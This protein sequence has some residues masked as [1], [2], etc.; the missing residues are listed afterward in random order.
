M[1]EANQRATFIDASGNPIDTALAT[2]SENK[3]G[4]AVAQLRLFVPP[5]FRQGDFFVDEGTD[6][7]ITD[8][9]ELKLRPER[10]LD[11]EGTGGRT[12]KVKFFY[13]DTQKKLHTAQLTYNITVLDVDETPSSMTLSESTIS[14]PEGS[15]PTGRKIAYIT[16]DDDALGQ[17]HATIGEHPIFEVRNGNELWIKEGVVLDFETARQHD[18]EVRPVVTGMGDAPAPVTLTLTVQ[19]VQLSL[20][21]ATIGTTSHPDIVQA[22]S[23]VGSRV[24]QVPVITNIDVP[25]RYEVLQGGEVS[26]NFYVDSQ[27]ALRIKTVLADRSVEDVELLIRAHAGGEVLERTVSFDI[28]SGYFTHLRETM[29]AFQGRKATFS[30]AGKHDADGDTYEIPVSAGGTRRVEDGFFETKFLGQLGAK[31]VNGKLTIELIR[32]DEA[33]FT[34][35]PGFIGT[36][37][38]SFTILDSRGDSAR[39]TV[40]FVIKPEMEV[41]EGQTASASWQ[42]LNLHGRSSTAGNYVEFTRLPTTGRFILLEESGTKTAVTVGM[43]I[44]ANDIRQGRLRYEAPDGIDAAIYETAHFVTHVYFNSGIVR[45]RSDLFAIAIR[46]EDGGS[47]EDPTGRI[48]LVPMLVSSK[49]TAGTEQTIRLDKFGA[50]SSLELANLSNLTFRFTIMPSDGRFYLSD[51]NGDKTVVNSTTVIRASDVENGR[52]TFTASNAVPDDYVVETAY[53]AIRTALDGSESVTDLRLDIHIEEFLVRDKHN[54]GAQRNQRYVWDG[55]SDIRFI[56]IGD[57]VIISATGADD[58]RSPLLD[59]R[60]DTGQ[61]RFFNSIHDVDGWRFSNM[62][63]SQMIL[64]NEVGGTHFAYVTDLSGYTGIYGFSIGGTGSLG[65]KPNPGYVISGSVSRDVAIRDIWSPIC[66]RV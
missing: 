58:N 32:K 10:S 64:H 48:P 1:T 38:I 62:Q 34:P 35:D 18:I 23:T 60:F 21:E 53:R 27:G 54:I 28:N 9:N 37:D 30:I 52:L 61:L 14:I 31:R 20:D 3:P 6:F 13:Y 16:F 12:A 46:N 11:F 7:Y 47:T 40:P 57:K 59:F 36:K 50:D 22:N 25:V 41:T 24:G 63:F 42:A 56:E 4:E 45:T 49:V 66:G 26:Q 55:A 44:H 15:Y 65:S 17:N 8:E 2:V 39:I 51:D 33:V 29:T 43:H 19:D 5:S